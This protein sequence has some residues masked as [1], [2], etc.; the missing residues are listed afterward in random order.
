MAVPVDVVGLPSRGEGRMPGKA[1][2]PG[3]DGVSALRG[4]PDESPTLRF[5]NDI[6]TFC[7]VKVEMTGRGFIH[8]EL[9]VTLKV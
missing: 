2:T 3:F 7:D 4:E 6:R 8:E 9:R 1:A 5:R